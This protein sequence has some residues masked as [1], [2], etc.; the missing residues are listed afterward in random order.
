MKISQGMKIIGKGW[1]QKPKG[2]RVKYQRH[3]DLTIEYTPGLDDGPLDSDIVAWRYAWKLYMSTKSDQDTVKED[4]MVNITVVDT[5]NNDINY[6]V[7][8]M[9]KVYNQ[10]N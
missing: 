6:Y 8:G 10:K 5:E 7:T 9:P 3:P 4:E 2:F 1:V